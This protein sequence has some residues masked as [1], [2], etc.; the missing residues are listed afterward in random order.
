MTAETPDPA[1]VDNRTEPERACANGHHYYTKQDGAW[2]CVACQHAHE[3]GVS[4]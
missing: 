2:I 1:P 4:A 3:P